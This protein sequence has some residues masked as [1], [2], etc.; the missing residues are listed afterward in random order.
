MI[1][2]PESEL[3]GEAQNAGQ[4][5]RQ[6]Q[7]GTVSPNFYMYKISRSIKNREVLNT[8]CSELNILGA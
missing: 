6:I 2:A 4:I 7:N 1:C 8:S 3:S 5:S